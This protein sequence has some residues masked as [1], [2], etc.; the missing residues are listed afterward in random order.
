MTK[1]LP[2]MRF[3]VSDYLKDTGHLSHEQHGVYLLVLFKMWQRGG[4]LND[5]DKENANLLGMTVSKWR[6][7]KE[8]L[9]AFL[10]AYGPDGARSITQKRLQIERNVAIENSE[11]QGQRAKKAA[12]ERWGRERAL[13]EASGNATSMLGACS[14]NAIV[15]NKNIPDR[16]ISRTLIAAGLG[17]KGAA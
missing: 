3:W 10:E 9:M 11:R 7:H 5:N 4:T 14:R 1:D 6:K 13:K 17:K 8:W 16:S 12:A 2:F 15:T